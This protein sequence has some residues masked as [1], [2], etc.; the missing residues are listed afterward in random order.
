MTL[1]TSLLSATLLLATIGSAQ[2]QDSAAQI[3]ARQGEMRV[4]AISLGTLGGMAQGKIDYDAEAA[5]IAADN[6]VAVSMIHQAPFWPEGSDE[7]GAS[8]TAAK[9]EI[10]EDWAGFESD[11][12]DFGTA[13]KAMQVAAGTGAEAIGPAMGALGGTCKGCHDDFRASRN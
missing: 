6:L 10:W 7:M 8:N 12:A 1:K 2:A 3:K 11:W 4:M 9:A 5:A 13:A